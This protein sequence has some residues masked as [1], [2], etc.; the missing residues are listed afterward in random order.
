MTPLRLFVIAYHCNMYSWESDLQGFGIGSSEQWRWN[1]LYAV[2]F[3]SSYW[4]RVSFCNK[5][6]EV[7]PAAF[8]HFCD[9]EARKTCCKEG[10]PCSLTALGGMIKMSFDPSKHFGETAAW[11]TES[12]KSMC[13]GNCR[14]CWCGKTFL[15][16]MVG[17]CL[18]GMLQG[19]SWSS[20]MVARQVM[21]Q[22]AE[23]A[24]V[25]SGLGCLHG[26]FSF[27]VNTGAHPP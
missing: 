16:V 12:E 10:L 26:G 9:K 21:K 17:L 2:C 22:N 25:E 1:D 24:L 20:R 6:W 19:E 18:C 13:C 4:G 3:C 5:F 11:P 23:W 7:M 15:L 8:Y 27:G 14:A